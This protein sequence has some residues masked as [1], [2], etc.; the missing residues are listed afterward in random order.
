MPSNDRKHKQT[1][2]QKF[3]EFSKTGIHL[4]AHAFFLNE[5]PYSK[6]NNVCQ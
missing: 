1:V 4:T 6:R 5:L 3:Y 2:I